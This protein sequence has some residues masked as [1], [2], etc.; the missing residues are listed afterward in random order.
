[1]LGPIICLIVVVVVLFSFSTWAQDDDVKI[2][3]YGWGLVLLAIMAATLI[4]KEVNGPYNDGQIDA[5]KGTQTHKIHYVYPKGDTI[6]SDTLY[7]KIRE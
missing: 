6:P 1:M 3:S 5:L 7:I 4:V 2:G